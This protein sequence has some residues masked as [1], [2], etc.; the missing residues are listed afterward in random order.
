MLQPAQANLVDEFVIGQIHLI[1]RIRRAV[2]ECL[3]DIPSRRP[4][5]AVLNE[6]L[7]N[8]TVQCHFPWTTAWI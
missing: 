1:L 6:R 5:S 7:I 8:V 4:M 2:V 3:P